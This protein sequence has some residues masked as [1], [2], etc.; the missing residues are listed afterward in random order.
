MLAIMLL[1]LL[2][3]VALVIDGGQAY[4]QR[5][6]MQNA[7]DA[8]SMAGAGAI[9]DVRFGGKPY[10]VVS[11]VVNNVATENGAD[12]VMLC[13]VIRKDGTSIGSCSNAVAVNDSAA[14]GVKVRVKDIRKTAFGRVVGIET[15]EAVTDAAATI[16]P[17]VGA[18]APWAICSSGAA[19]DFLTPD[20]KVDPVKAAA[21][22][23]IVIQGS[24]IYKD[25]NNCDAKSGGGGGGASFKGVIGGPFVQAGTV[26]IVP[27]DPGNNLPAGWQEALVPCPVAPTTNS[28]V[29]LPV[30]YKVEGTGSNA[31]VYT[32][33]FAYFRV[34]EG[35]T[36]NDQM[37][38]TFV[39][40][41]GPGQPPP[42]AVT[43]TGD[44]TSSSVRTA[45]LIQ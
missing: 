35:Q 7:V 19:Y 30:A 3:I 37:L 18:K 4:A 39:G 13:D 11:T 32:A 10:T 38:G 2:A 14:V 12:E 42:G 27:N 28:C 21:L 36:G 26:T 8:A 41:I 24:Q 25:D 31:A 43:G 15:V 45:A 22:G 23:E 33:D 5:R 44:L 9:D 34:R 1:A 17:I 6:Q 16:Q 29:L 20:Y 40:V